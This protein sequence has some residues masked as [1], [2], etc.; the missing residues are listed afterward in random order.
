M[1]AP[2]L[3][4][5]T[6]RTVFDFMLQHGGRL[7]KLGD[8]IA[9]WEY[10]AWALPYV[11]DAPR[12]YADIPD[13]WGYHLATLDAGKLLDAPIP[14]LHFASAGEHPE[15]R[16]QI[17]KWVDIL[18]ESEGGWSSFLRLVEW[19]AWSLGVSSEPPRLD[20]KTAEALYRG[21]NLIPLLKH[22][23]DYLGSILAER[24]GGGKFWNPTAFYP[25]PHNVVE[26]M[27]QM[28][29]GEGEDLRAKS[30]CDPCVGTGRMLMHASNY[31]LNLWGMDIDPV[32]CTITRIH[33]ALYAPWMVFPLP[34][35]ILGRE[36]PPPP[37]APLPVPAAY[38]PPAGVH[39]FRCDDRGQGLLFAEEGAK[40]AAA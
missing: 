9:P 5:E 17:E 24:K 26:M 29:M 36:L 19:L 27:V 13:R 28:L 10:R 4:V 1:A 11:Q 20:P 16:R 39:A 35:E 37:P 22:P 2:A 25:T 15:V 33:G 14:R 3:A 34:A 31:S 40:D 30:V 18:G 8:A 21:V 32:V 12:F 6:P 7:P 38:Q 23:S